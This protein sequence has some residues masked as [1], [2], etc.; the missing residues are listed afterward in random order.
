MKAARIKMNV[1]M[2]IITQG[3]RCFSGGVLSMMAWSR[4]VTRSFRLVIF[5]LL[6]CLCVV[7]SFTFIF[8]RLFFLCQVVD[9]FF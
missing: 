7:F 8:I 5:C 4:K 6:S 2:V 1:I 3:S 9:D